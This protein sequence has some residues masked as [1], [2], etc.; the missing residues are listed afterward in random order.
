MRALPAGPELLCAPQPRST[1]PAGCLPTRGEVGPDMSSAAHDSARAV[2]RP[3]VVPTPEA[4]PAREVVQAPDALAGHEV[5][6]ARAVLDPS[7]RDALALL[8]DDLQRRDAAARTRRAYR[9]DLEQFARWMSARGLAPAEVDPRAVRRFVAHLSERGAAATTTAR[10]LAAVRALFNSQREHGRVS[11]NPADL[12]S[13]PR[14]PSQLP[15]VLSARDA[16][17]L[18]DAIPAGGPLELRDRAMFELAYGCGL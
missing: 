9:M 2:R 1:G 8:Q 4:A 16:A 5:P 15:R 17:R 12:V 6:P 14:R 10:K 11:H 3:G 7:W 13:T 18:L